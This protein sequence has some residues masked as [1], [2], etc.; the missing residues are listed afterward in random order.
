[1]I[2]FVVDL[3]VHLNLR[4]KQMVLPLVAPAFAKVVPDTRIRFWL[5]V[6]DT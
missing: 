1:M 3:V 6:F 4:V 2:D 5:A